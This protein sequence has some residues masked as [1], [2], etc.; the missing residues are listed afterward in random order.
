MEPLVIL[1]VCVAILHIAAELLAKLSVPRVV[2][3][4]GTGMVLGLPF[5]RDVLFTDES[6]SVLRF[7]GYIGS[8][9][10]L[11]FVGLQLDVRKTVSNL[12][13]SAGISFF[14][15]SLPLVLGLLVSHWFGLSWTVSL[16]VGVCM[17][18]SATALALDLLEEFG[19]LRTSLGRLI[20]E[21]GAFDDL[22][23]MLLVAGILSVIGAA[24]K[25][26]GLIL[27]DL[28]IFLAI[29]LAFR[30]LLI[31]WML[32]NAIEK[33]HRPTLFSGALIMTLL[34]A[35]LADY[36]GVGA[37]IGALFGGMITRQVLLKDDHHRPWELME[38][39]RDVHAI[40]FGFLIPFF[41]LLV[42]LNSDLMAIWNNL[43]FSVA[44]T[45]IAIF[46]T[47]VGSAI[48]YW[49][50][51]RHWKDAW[52]VGWALNAKGDTE[53]VIAQLALSAGLISRDIFSSLI[54]MA[55]VSTLI[56]P[57]VFKRLLGRV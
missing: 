44:I 31:P 46:G 41:F 53:L 21:A 20:V 36:L 6:M 35:V 52:L 3:Q 1:L 40:G 39:S 5:I 55:V 19:K 25:S 24:S 54:F 4:V 47:V 33:E 15:T 2:A 7:F 18:V 17:S 13:V 14:N 43:G 28:F 11:Y 37:L 9:L 48:G 45:V 57:F 56:S 26:F 38:I 34:L 22:V 50:V 27:A 42:G 23:E 16:I 30:L 29:V 49:T 10:L 8:I 32:R 51:K 12:P